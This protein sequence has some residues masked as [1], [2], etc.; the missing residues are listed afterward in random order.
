MCDDIIVVASVGLGWREVSVSDGVCDGDI[1]TMFAR[2]EQ[3]MHKAQI[4]YCKK[5]EKSRCNGKKCQISNRMYQMWMWG[6]M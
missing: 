6:L 5:W 2:R 3:R 4:I 1:V